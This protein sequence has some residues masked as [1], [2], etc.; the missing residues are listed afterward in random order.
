MTLQPIHQAIFELVKKQS[1]K[2]LKKYGCPVNPDAL[3]PEEWIQHLKEELAD[4]LVYIT[5]L[6]HHLKKKG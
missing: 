2:G 1:D 3:P 5:A 6:E 4:A